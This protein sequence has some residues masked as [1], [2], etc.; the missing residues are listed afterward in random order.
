MKH[1]QSGSVL[2]FSL[3]ILFI[4]SFIGVASM[5]NVTLNERMASNYRDHD[6]VFQAAEAALIEGESVAA[7]YTM[8]FDNADFQP[9]CSTGDCFSTAC[10]NGL[11]FNG[12]YPLGGV[13]DVTT[14]AN[15]LW[16]QDATWSTAGRARSAMA[17]FPT[18]PVKPKYIIEFMC[19]V[20]ADPSAGAPT[21]EPAYDV[22]WS[23]MYRVTAYA[24]G[25]TGGSRVMLQ[26]TFKQ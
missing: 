23:K 25:A 3:M 5:E 8:S 17:S 11:C 10:T 20:T 21:P 15:P 12:S 2:L 1:R 19:F 18:L 7:N 24:E 14:L 26:S 4:L 9:S 13:C 16:L 6:V 22:T